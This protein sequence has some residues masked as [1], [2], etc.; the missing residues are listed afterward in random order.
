MPSRS[1]RRRSL[2]L[3][4][5]AASACALAASTALAEPETVSLA[6]VRGPGAEAC[7]SQS[8]VVRQITS[9]L[10]RS[11][12]ASD[13]E[14]SIDAYVSHAEAGWRA[15]IYVRDRDGKLAGARV[16]TSEAADC[17]AIESATVLALALAIDPEG[18][19]RAPDPAPVLAPDPAPIVVPPAPAVTPRPAPL[20]ITHAPFAAADPPSIGLGGS[21]VALRGAVGLG[22]LP[23]AAAGVSL[24]A[25]AAITRSWAITAEA[26]WMPE[27]AAADDRF[28]F[29][30]S[31]VALG[32]CVGV[33]R[34]SSVDLAACG[35]IWAGALHAVVRDLP[36]TEPGDRA[37]AAASV[38]P[39]LR[40]RLAPRL[41]LELGAQVLVPL[42]RQPF[43]VT[44]WAEP[45]FQQTPI[46][47]L[48]FAGLG[49]NFP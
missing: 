7:P 8:A 24:A 44:G 3:A 49:V 27:V 31:A 19:L 39:R 33:A 20:P 17:G 30:L 46:A 16:L 1:A 23:R 11:P 28:A 42:I 40:L 18:A 13:A 48:P 4:A 41:H 37:W 38:T 21:G 34:S 43:T 29:G 36:P 14:R 26:L 15:E 25:H 47:V 6:W 2:L 22:L 12:F 5:M 10:G 45:V 9:R 35:A 32:A